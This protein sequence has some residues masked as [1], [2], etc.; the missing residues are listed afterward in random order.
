MR[1]IK[2]LLS[3]SLLVGLNNVVS[4]QDYDEAAILM[5]VFEGTKGYRWKNKEGWA[6]AN[7]VCDWYGVTCYGDN[8][9]AE[10]RNR[11]AKLDL[12]ENK[13]VGNLPQ[14][15]FQLKYMYSIVLRDNPDLVVTVKQI[16]D[17]VNLKH[18]TLSNTKI[19]SLDRLSDAKNTLTRLQLTDCEL[20]GK[21]PSEIYQLTKLV[22]LLANYNDFTGQISPDIGNLSRLQ[23]LFLYENRLT[24]NIPSQV[25]RLTDLKII[26]MAN[27]AF[28]G[29]LPSEMN[30]L[31]NLQV[32]AIQREDGDIHGPGINGPLLDFDRMKS[33]KEV[34]LQNQRIE[35]SI[36]YDFLK[37]APRDEA[38]TVDLRNNRLSGHVPGSL[39]R[40]SNMKLYLS[41]DK[42]DS[43]STS[44][45]DNTKWMSGDV[46]EHG[47]NDL[48]ILYSNGSK[49]YNNT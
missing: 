22:A 34:Y 32:L 6:Q 48:L 25:G 4:G 18:L 8:D 19:S 16:G 30:N 37:S 12:S 31:V 29:N 38:M 24:G 23:E 5:K 40:H 43:M 44:L 46:K 41:G 14:E 35:G 28:S 20:G 10:Q 2:T 15:I 3:T 17:A 47:C 33:L 36:S 26:A 45:C 11:V 1:L 39:D 42:F 9:P 21:I 49:L 27:N 13:L 7:S